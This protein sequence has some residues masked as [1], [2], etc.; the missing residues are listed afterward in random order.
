MLGLGPMLNG[1]RGVEGGKLRDRICDVWLGG[2][3]QPLQGTYQVG[4]R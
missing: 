2:T 4:V 3:G 1:P